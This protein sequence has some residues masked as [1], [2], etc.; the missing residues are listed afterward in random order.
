[1]DTSL[2][3]EPIIQY[4]FIGFSAVLLGII[5][6]LIKQLLSA[7]R[8]THRVIAE[9]TDVVKDLHSSIKEITRS[10]Q[11]LHDKIISRPCISKRE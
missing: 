5:I 4:G 3:L 6:W 9:N 8:M 10:Q 7:M 11:R 1:M 2:F